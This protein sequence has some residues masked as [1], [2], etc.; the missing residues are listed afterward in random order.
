MILSGEISLKPCIRAFEK[1]TTGP[2]PPPST[3][4]LFLNAPRALVFAL[5]TLKLCLTQNNPFSGSHL[6]QN[7]RF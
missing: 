1:R 4:T 3:Y 2:M 5:S 7:P 6:A